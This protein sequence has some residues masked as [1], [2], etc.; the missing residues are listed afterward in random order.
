[1]IAKVKVTNGSTF[2]FMTVAVAIQPK[3]MVASK[4]P[5]GTWTQV[6]C[7]RWW[8]TLSGKERYTK[9]MP[10]FV[11]LTCKISIVGSSCIG[12]LIKQTANQTMDDNFGETVKL[13][14]IL[15]SARYKPLLADH[16]VQST[17]SSYV[18]F[19][20]YGGKGV[21]QMEAE[22]CGLQIHSS[23]LSFSHNQLASWNSQSDA[24]GSP[25][26]INQ[27]GAIWVK[28][29][30]GNYY[31]APLTICGHGLTVKCLRLL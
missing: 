19:A 4:L 8:E 16:C 6:G 13:I 20:R 9:G 21:T 22:L 25:D 15:S 12:A 31:K 11:Y 14:S 24:H 2:G 18:R 26:A 29:S 7:K 30:I 23:M 17:V 1:M 3:L 28:P 27:K 10:P 5:R